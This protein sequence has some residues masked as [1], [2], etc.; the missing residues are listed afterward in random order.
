MSERASYVIDEAA[1]S[2]ATESIDGLLG[3]DHVLQDV[4]TTAKLVREH[5]VKL[6]LFSEMHLQ[7]FNHE[8]QFGSRLSVC[9]SILEGI[10]RLN[11]NAMREGHQ[12][13]QGRYGAMVLYASAAFNGVV[14]LVESPLDKSLFDLVAAGGIVLNEEKR[15]EGDLIGRHVL[16]SRGLITERRYGKKTEVT[17]SPVGTRTVEVQKARDEFDANAE[18]H[19]GKP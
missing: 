13:N 9:R 4:V 8:Y 10:T 6:E 18:A 7:V 3:F 12:T 15:V 11:N 5:E 16:L 2:Q 1:R 17:P 19:P 14:D